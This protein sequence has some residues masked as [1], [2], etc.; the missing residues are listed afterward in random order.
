[1]RMCRV[2]WKSFADEDEDLAQSR[3]AA[4]VQRTAEGEILLLDEYDS[5]AI[6]ARNL[7]SAVGRTRIDEYNLV[8]IAPRLTLK[9][10]KN[11]RQPICLVQGANDNTGDDFATHDVTPTERAPSGVSLVQHKYTDSD[12]GGKG[13]PN[14][15]SGATV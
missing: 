11:L 2:S 4:D 13:L 10:F 5:R 9:L 8:R 1:M 7:D 12:P 6:A 15:H 14:G 3:I